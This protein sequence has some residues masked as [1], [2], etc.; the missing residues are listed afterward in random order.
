MLHR[1][2]S[3]AVILTSLSV[4]VMPSFAHAQNA[5][6]IQQ[7]LQ[8]EWTDFAKRV[9]PGLASTGTITVAPAGSGYTATLPTMRFNL[10]NNTSLNLDKVTVT[11]KPDA[12]GVI[13]LAITLPSTIPNMTG[14]NNTTPVG[15]VTIGSQSLKAVVKPVDGTWQ[16][17]SVNGQFGTV[18][19]KQN[20][21]SASSVAAAMP[22]HATIS[23]FSVNGQ[24]GQ[25]NVTAS[26]VKTIS[27]AGDIQTID[28]LVLQ[29]KTATN[30]ALRLSDIFV[31]LA[32][33]MPDMNG[34]TGG[35]G[36]WLNGAANLS[37]QI[38]NLKNTDSTGLVLTSVDTLT[39][40]NAI[41]QADA[42]KIA[43]RSI[44]DLKNI[45]VN[46]PA[47]FAD[48][49]P[50]NLQFTTSLRNLPMQYFNMA[51]STPEE[52]A[53]ARMALANAQTQLQIDNLQVDTRSGL[54][55]NGTGLLTSTMVP[56]TY[57]T[58][59]VTLN[60][61][62]LQDTMTKLQQSMSSPSAGS[63]NAPVMMALMMLQ[64]LGQTNNSQPNQTQYVVTFTP[65]GKTL[66]NNQDLS[67]LTKLA[68]GAA[69]MATGGIK[70]APAVP[71]PVAPTAPTAPSAG[72]MSTWKK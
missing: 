21:N 9:G 12:S 22:V 48:T 49:A 50:R 13:N 35:L 17:Q 47:A 26:G 4:F 36:K 60:L 16:I 8:A 10:Q 23:R 30:G 71:T 20:T 33:T 58:G 3:A 51:F 52:K 59:T 44:G 70:P 31:M 54:K 69:G 15:A 55:A 32:D 38:K 1:S 39:L 5:T 37:I 66:L 6:D 56:P 28:Q 11:A 24:P 14:A 65:D 25:M 7:Q 61:V 19:W 34:S 27:N 41:T 43:V 29:Q 68:T 67:G 45:H 62:N 40:D 57:T 18:A 42:G 72:G 64:G 53:L 46:M 2:A 63:N